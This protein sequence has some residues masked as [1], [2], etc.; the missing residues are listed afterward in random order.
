MARTEIDF[1]ELAER[2]QKLERQYC[3]WK[4]ASFF[5]LFIL[6]CLLATGLVAQG[7]I[8]PPLVRAKAV[9]AQSFLLEDAN[10]TVRGQMKMKAGGPSFEIYDETGKIVWSIPSKPVQKPT[11]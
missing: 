3:R 7:K 9:E 6:A 11:R 8:E 2:V 10:G 4:L 1:R 5:L